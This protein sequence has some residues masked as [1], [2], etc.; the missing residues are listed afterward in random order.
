MQKQQTHTHSTHIHH[1]PNTTPNTM[2]GERRKN[3]EK[4]QR[5][6]EISH[7]GQKRAKRVQNKMKKL[8]NQKRERNNPGRRSSWPVYLSKLPANPRL[9]TSPSASLRICL[10][11]SSE[12]NSEES[13]KVLLVLRNTRAKNNQNIISRLFKALANEACNNFW[14]CPRALLSPVLLFLV[15]RF[16][17]GQFRQSG[18]DWAVLA[19]CW[20]HKKQKNYRGWNKGS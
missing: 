9:M 20:F 11:H 18:F 13:G 12:G 15:I 16:M 6:I 5:R 17:V 2:D 14:P 3:D 19:A 4:K 1:S 10:Q 8:C 7:Y